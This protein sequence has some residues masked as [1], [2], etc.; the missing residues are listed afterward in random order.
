MNTVSSSI[1]R[2]MPAELGS[3]SVCVS[4]WESGLEVKAAG[5]G[6]HGLV[7]GWQSR[8]GGIFVVERV[9]LCNRAFNAGL[10]DR[11][12]LIVRC[13]A[14]QSSSR[15]RPRYESSSGLTK[16][17]MDLLKK[18]EEFMSSTG[19]PLDKVP[20]TR[21][22]A[23]NGRQDLANAVRRRGYKAVAKLLADKKVLWRKEE[24]KINNENK[25]GSTVSLSCSKELLP[26]ADNLVRLGD[27]DLCKDDQAITPN[28]SSRTIE[29][30][31]GPSLPKES[32]FEAS[33]VNDAN[34]QKL[35]HGVNGEATISPVKSLFQEEAM[36]FIRSDQADGNEDEEE[37][38]HNDD[39]QQNFVDD[40]HVNSSVSETDQHTS[41]HFGTAE[42][43]AARKATVDKDYELDLQ[44]QIQVELERIKMALL[45]R[46]LELAK[47]SR[48]LEEA[49]AQLALFHAKATAELTQTKQALLEKELSLQAAQQALEHLKQ[50]Q[51]EWWGE[52]SKVELAGSFNGWQYN[53]P[54]D[55]DP[56]SEIA[57]LDGSRGP[58]MWGTKLWLYPGFYEIKF[59]VDGNWTIDQRREIV[60]R[61]MGQNNVL[62]VDG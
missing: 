60:M 40:N 41:S 49:K 29:K 19:L 34:G 47:M 7:G 36:E 42:T 50:V 3:L 14:S 1:V 2:K 13:R 35:F 20:S 16:S 62:R 26:V 46:E 17:D 38:S 59:I 48:E 37:I 43:I 24:D 10:D 11:R 51:V 61:N 32:P 45:S 18:L 15:K 54:M 27:A 57:N 44:R 58:M 8:R 4:N 12:L 28:P 56:S 33:L 21:E 5:A 39:V 30:T 6:G 53:F 55:P 31:A 25:G 23:G 9:M 22:L 52:G